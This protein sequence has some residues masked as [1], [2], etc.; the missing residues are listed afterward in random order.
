MRKRHGLIYHSRLHVLVTLFV[1]FLPFL[2]FLLFA[3]ATKIA[4][5]T[6]YYDVFISIVRLG[7]SYIIALAFA[8]VI[9]VLF[10]QGRRSAIVLPIADVLQSFP[11]FAALPLATLYW[12]VNNTTII[13]FMVITVIWPILFSIISSLKL[14]KHEWREAV[15]MSGLR[16]FE[17][18]RYFLFPVTLPGI[19]TGSIIGLGDGWE[20]IVG[21]EIIVGIRTGLGGFFEKFS[22]NPTITFFGIAGL[23]LIIFAIN[24]IIWLPLLEHSHTLIEE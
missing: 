10:Y 9:A 4:V 16:G 17:Y 15:E 2:F 8:W 12:G 7:V 14:I 19:V 6:L 3:E 21:T 23:L 13:V 5:T 18:V 20:A 1:V 24:K 22:T 11:T